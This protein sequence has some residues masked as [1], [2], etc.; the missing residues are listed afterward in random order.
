MWCVNHRRRT[1]FDFNIIEREFV[2]VMR[3]RMTYFIEVLFSSQSRSAEAAD[4]HRS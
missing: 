2:G 4:S 3:L 1:L